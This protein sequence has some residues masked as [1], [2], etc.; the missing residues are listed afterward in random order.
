M[1]STD[2]AMVWTCRLALAVAE[3]DKAEIEAVLGEAMA[4]PDGTALLLTTMAGTIASL[5][6]EWSGANWRR[7]LTDSIQAMQ[8]GA[9]RASR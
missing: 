2:A 4:K 1:T 9:S 8:D 6:S 3:Q 7:A 5:M